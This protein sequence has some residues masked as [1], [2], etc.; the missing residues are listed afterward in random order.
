MFRHPTFI[1]EKNQISMIDR[2]S[3]SV[4]CF[5]A[6]NKMPEIS[7]ISIKSVLKNSDS[8]IIVG[9]LR[10]S[11]VQDLPK[12][13]RIKYLRL[14]SSEEIN[15]DKNDSVY[16]DFSQDE[17]FK[18]VQYKWV[19][20]KEIMKMNYTNIIYS[21]LDVVWVSDACDL[22]NSTFDNRTELHVLVQSF[23]S[24]PAHPRLCMGFFAFRNSTVSSKLIE[25]AQEMHKKMS[26]ISPRIGDDEVIT[27][28][29]SQL[30][31]P[32]WLCELPQSTF[33]VGN[34]L[35]LY[36]QRP[37]FPGLHAP[38][39]TIF[40]ANYVVGI[41]NKRI[42]MRLFLSNAMKKDLGVRNSSKLSLVLFAKR[43]KNYLRS[44]KYLVKV[45][46]V[47]RTNR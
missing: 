6:I 12:D 46:I 43:I 13:D 37:R 15:L 39:P 3:N 19:L 10:G 31:Y 44:T 40:H 2:N 30:K 45:H 8:Q 41:R 1:E 5:L 29:Y 18:L 4:V 9:Y 27:E 47:N 22:V 21:D 24:S 32:H 20:F 23:S 35:T 7:E 28:L 38:T 17:F 26:S 16:R 36:S 42:L 25:T 33:P 34:M 11:D 14:E